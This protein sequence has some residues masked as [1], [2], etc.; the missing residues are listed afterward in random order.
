MRYF[1]WYFIV[2]QYIV[3][4]NQL[5]IHIHI[6]VHLVHATIHLVHATIHLVH[7]TIQP[8]TTFDPSTTAIHRPIIWIPAALFICF[9]RINTHFL[10]V[11]PHLVHQILLLFLFLVYLVIHFHRLY[12]L[13]FHIF[14]LALIQTIFYLFFQYSLVFLK[15]GLITVDQPVLY[16]QLKPRLLS[17]VPVS[18]INIKHFILLKQTDL[19]TNN[20]KQ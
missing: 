17:E 16:V 6:H 10:K 9:C 15:C 1:Y 19:P 13:F 12:S 3:F 14:Y 5:I 7:V 18:F 11:L 8:S 4:S 20:N 2:L